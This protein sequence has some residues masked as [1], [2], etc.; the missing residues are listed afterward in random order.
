MAKQ[1]INLGAAANDGK[2]DPLRT[3]FGKVNANFDELFARTPALYRP[4][5]AGAW[6]PIN[7]G[8]FDAGIG[9]VSDGLLWT[10]FLIATALR[11]DALL[12]TI[13]G[14]SST[15]AIR[16]YIYASGTDG[17]PGGAPLA[18]TGEL[19]AAVAQAV[20]GVLN[21]VTLQPGL[22]W[23]AVHYKDA[24]IAVASGAQMEAV[25]VI[26]FDSMTTIGSWY[27]MRT[28]NCPFSAGP[29]TITA[30]PSFY[31][32]TNVK[33]LPNGFYRVAA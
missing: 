32:G 29:P 1:S 26:G 33:R 14:T 13:S 16:L 15:G 19:S 28:G 10:P 8:A 2:G 12:T 27:G 22:Y 9:G 25:S 21:P 3:A 6:Y 5:R 4:N 18:A 7:T 17:Y 31:G 24:N 23:F 30:P 20:M 11:I